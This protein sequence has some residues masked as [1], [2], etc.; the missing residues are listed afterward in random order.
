MQP[1][2]K[3][4]WR[5]HPA[6]VRPSRKG[7]PAHHKQPNRPLIETRTLLTKWTLLKTDA[8]AVNGGRPRPDVRDDDCLLPRG[9][10]KSLGKVL[11]K[12]GG[13]ILFEFCGNHLGIGDDGV[14]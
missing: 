10:M 9:F 11:T 3:N 7:F 1:Q 14:F 5:R 2:R 4:M 8:S 6:C 12:N 13:K